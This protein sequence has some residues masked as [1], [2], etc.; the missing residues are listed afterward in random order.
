VT[1]T[2]DEPRG[3]LDPTVATSSES[4][5]RRWAAQL[6]RDDPERI[7]GFGVVVGLG[8]VLGVGA[9][10]FF[11]WL[12]D[13]VLEQETTALDSAAT[14][15]VLQ[16]K[17]PWLDTVMPIISLFGSEVVFVLGGLLFVLFAWQ[18]RWGAAF[19]LVLVTAGAWALNNLLKDVFRRTRPEPVTS[20][21]S[22]QQWSFPSGHA[23]VS[24]AFYFFLAYLAWRLTVGIWRWVLVLGLLTL[25]LLIGISRI[26][27]QAHYLSDVIAGY[28]AGFLWTDAVIV[29]SRLLSTRRRRTL[30]T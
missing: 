26:Y 25:V 20:L 24:A 16:F 10:Y 3:Q 15:F 17:S 27:L 2:S 13:Q 18:R 21:L 28:A 29:G 30:T 6:G 19:L 22:A 11:A 8:F 4:G 23:M 7:A 9:I 5:W 1:T 14:A 12:A